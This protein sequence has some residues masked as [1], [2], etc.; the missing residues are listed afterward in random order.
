[1]SRIDRLFLTPTTVLWALL[2]SLSSCSSKEE[3]SQKHY[4][5]GVKLFEQGKIGKARVELLN[6]VQLQPEMADAY[7]YL[8][9]VAEKGK[10]LP[11]Y[12]ENMTLAAQLDPQN[13]K[14]M[15]GVGK[16]LLSRSL[17]EEALTKAEE[18]LTADPEYYDGILLQ[19]NALIN[20]GYLEQAQ[21][22]IEKATAISKNDPSLLS[23]R[24][25]MAELQGNRDQALSLLN[26]AITHSTDKSQ[27]LMQRL[28][29]HQRFGDIEGVLSDLED[30]STNSP[31]DSFYVFSLSKMLANLK[32]Y[33]ESERILDTFIAHQPGNTDAKQF[34]VE[35][36]N[37]R[38]QDRA[39]KLLSEYIEQHPS[40]PSFRFFRISKNI[41]ANKTKTASKELQ[42]IIDNVIF[43]AEAKRH[44]R[45]ILATIHLIDNQENQALQLI[46]TNLRDDPTH[47]ESLLFN[48]RIDLKY[49]NY[50]T[51]INNARKALRTNPKSESAL[52]LLGYAFSESGSS[53]LANDSFR[54]ALSLNPKNAKAA[55]PI[56]QELLSNRDYT[57]AQNILEVLLTSSENDLSFLALSAKIKVMKE[58]WAGAEHT[59][60]KLRVNGAGKIDLNFLQGQIHQGRGNYKAAINNYKTTLSAAPQ[61]NAALEALG[62]CYF[63]LNQPEE[64]LKFLVSFQ[65]KNPAALPAYALA[66][67]TYFSQK[68]Y[69]EAEKTLEKGLAQNKAWLE[70]YVS[71]GRLHKFQ[72]NI[73]SA[74]EVYIRGILNTKNNKDLQLLLAQEYQKKNDFPAAEKVYKN[75]LEQ[76]GGNLAAINNYALL[77]VES[78]DSSQKTEQLNQLI[79]KLEHTANPAYL[80]TLG[81]VITHNGD[82]AKGEGYLRR[83]LED[84]PKSAEIHFHLGISLLEQQRTG[85][86]KQ[87]FKRTISLAP[88]NDRWKKMIDNVMEKTLQ[89]KAK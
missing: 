25:G 59:L 34:L 16:I 53:E 50:D 10:D 5:Q 3:S 64:L 1:M 56:I 13:L 31:N 2:F 76:D 51:S 29:M 39:D 82:A 33:T 7:Y 37:L 87:S 65:A 54:E 47:E 21:P 22:L 46:K 62:L 28:K 43:D 44:A 4:A 80:D 6:A 38:D 58:D 14:A 85:E 70:G 9:L 18:I 45:V 63:R 71:L 89:N 20:L 88:K 67:R 60:A 68:E 61:H 48:A 78:P 19:I 49:K 72:N 26:E 84:L 81:W 11:Q 57:R 42:H 30:L 86:A 36:V 55:M 40:S 52:I 8:G 27:A 32:R 17:F 23:L 69:A 75:L 77:L 15:A 73:D 12:Y 41:N 83:A 66:G 24:A 74:I 35:M 79:Q